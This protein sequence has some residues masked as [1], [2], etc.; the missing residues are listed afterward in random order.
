MEF[1]KIPLHIAHRAA[2]VYR[3]MMPYVRKFISE[4]RQQK[5]ETEETLTAAE[6]IKKKPGK[7][8]KVVK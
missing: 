7:T 1:V 6:G 2:K 4:Q 5:I 8:N 3:P